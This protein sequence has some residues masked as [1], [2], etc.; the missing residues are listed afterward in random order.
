MTIQREEEAEM[1]QGEA[2]RGIGIGRRS[3]IV[4]ARGI[5]VDNS[6]PSSRPLLISFIP[7][8]GPIALGRTLIWGWLES[9]MEEREQKTASDRSI[10]LRCCARPSSV[11]KWLFAAGQLSWWH[12]RARC[13]CKAS[14]VFPLSFPWLPFSHENH[15]RSQK[16]EVHLMG[17]FGTKKLIFFKTKGIFFSFLKIFGKQKLNCFQ[18]SWKVFCA[19]EVWFTLPLISLNPGKREI[20]ENKSY[21]ENKSKQP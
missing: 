11:L 9:G 16:W 5:Q 1:V 14:L 18:T 13:N 4:R 17:F 2:A 21:V 10:Y 6:A 8:Q 19:N 12:R 7:N 20:I 15:K 3:L